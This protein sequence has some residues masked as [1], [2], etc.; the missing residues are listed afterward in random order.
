MNDWFIKKDFPILDKVKKHVDEWSNNLD[1]DAWVYD[2]WQAPG[3]KSTHIDIPNCLHNEIQS[4]STLPLYNEWYIWD[5]IDAK[6]L[7]IHKDSNST[8]GY[9]SIAFIIAIEGNFENQIYKDDQ[10]TL[11]DSVVYGPGEGI[12]LNNT[13][14]R[15]SGK[16]LSKT[17]KTIS[18]W[19]D[20][21]E[22]D[23]SKSLSEMI[24]IYKL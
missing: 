4:I 19:I 24:S 22:T 5:F 20:F 9:R 6:E 11:I 14:Y 7:I 17:R 1:R 12:I 13:M 15:H 18:C 10:K 23:F 21:K 8:G 16:V 3:T 2:P